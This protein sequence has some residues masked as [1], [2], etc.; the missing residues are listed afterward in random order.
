MWA[1]HRY[2]LDELRLPEESRMRVPGSSCLAASE[3]AEGGIRDSEY[4][5]RA[6]VAPQSFFAVEAWAHTDVGVRL[7]TGTPSARG[8]GRLRSAEIIA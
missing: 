4:H 2:A 6:S 8:R 1:A 3:P 5:D 7:I